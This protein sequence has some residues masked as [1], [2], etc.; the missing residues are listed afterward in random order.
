MCY[1]IRK[2]LAHENLSRKFV[3]HTHVAERVTI[4]CNFWRI[5]RSVKLKLVAGSDVVR[6]VKARYGLV[7]LKV[8]LNSM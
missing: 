8:L 2:N 7:V 3:C 1:S 6:S 5:C 4:T